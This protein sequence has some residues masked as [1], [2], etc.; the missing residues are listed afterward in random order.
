MKHTESRSQ[1]AVIRW[2][3]Y[4]HRG[5]GVAD[6]RMLFSV[7]NGGQRNAVT[8]AILKAEGCRAGV[9][10]LFL[11]VMRAHPTIDKGERVR[12]G[13]FIEMKRLGGR[14]TEAQQQMQELLCAAGYTVAV[15]HSTDEA[16]RTIETYLKS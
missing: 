13:L 14:S 6:E 10:D 12:G 15:C 16:I 8:G 1:Q 2:W 5:L 4:A 9:P 3:K 7:P 11:S